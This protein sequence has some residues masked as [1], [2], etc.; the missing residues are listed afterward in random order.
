MN[1]RF[2]KFSALALTATATL[3]ANTV[4]DVTVTNSG[5]APYHGT[6][7]N[8]PNVTIL[9]DDPYDV[10][11]TA[12]TS[13]NVLFLN[14]LSATTLSQTI[15]GA[16][17][18]ANQGGITHITRAVTLATKLYDEVAYLA[19]Q[20]GSTAAI[21]TAIQVAVW[22]VFDNLGI[23]AHDLAPA[24]S[25]S[26]SSN[27]DSL[28]WLNKAVADAALGANGI[29]AKNASRI[30]ILTPGGSLGSAMSQEFIVVTPEPATYAMLGSGLILLA[31]ATFR[32]R[33]TRA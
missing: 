20:F 5:T 26:A 11:T 12:T 31:M 9:C 14:N 24:L 2:F 22:H 10:L 29:G 28:F 25:S 23:T 33:K 17:I 30:E 1:G 27:T 6:V 8:T 16:T 18:L 15:Y 21:N 13:D 19:L 3:F 4:V 32:R 7:G